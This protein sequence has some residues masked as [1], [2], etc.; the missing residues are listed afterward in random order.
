ME[1]VNETN[2]KNPSPGYYYIK[3]R[4]RSRTRKSFLARDQKKKMYLYVYTRTRKP[5]INTTGTKY[6]N[7]K[8][9]FFFFNVILSTHSNRIGF[10]QVE[11]S[12]LPGTGNEN[13][14]ETKIYVQQVGPVHVRAISRFVS[15]GAFDGVVNKSR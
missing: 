6:R 13:R 14:Y 4:S 12:I 5:Q 8:K 2:E 7:R 9:N 1:R 15:G 3:Y 11:M 10:S